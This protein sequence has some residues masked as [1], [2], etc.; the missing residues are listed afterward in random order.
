MAAQNLSGDG[1]QK[2]VSVLSFSLDITPGLHG[3]LTFLSVLNTFMSV[4]AFLGNALILI[5]LHRVFASATAQTLSL[6]PCSNWSLCWSY[7]RDSLC[8]LLHVYSERLLEYVPLRISCGLYNGQYILRSVG[9]DTDCNK[10]R[11]TSRSVVET[12]IQTSCNFKAN[13]LDR[14]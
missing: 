3:Q 5:A 9:V 2:A 13:L 14:Y 7:C 1:Q 8:Y 11:Q 10:R 4:T 6:L 12:E